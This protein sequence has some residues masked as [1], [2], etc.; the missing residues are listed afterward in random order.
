MKE[1]GPF[2]SKINQD[3]QWLTISNVLTVIRIIITPT[4]L[5]GIFHK[6]WKITFIIFI[7]TA[8]SDTLDG[9]LARYFNQKTI[10]GSILD[11]I[12]D[13]FFI[14]CCFSALTFFPS[15]SFQIPLWFFCLE[16][17]REATMIIGTYIVIKKATDVNIEPTIF[18]KLN[19][20][21]HTIFISWIFICNFFHWHP[22]KTF[23]VLLFTIALFSIM[24]LI[25]Y[26][27]LGIKIVFKNKT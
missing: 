6:E 17:F 2:K 16:I 12:A 19:T 22:E 10:L 4:I 18:G 24:S 5:L 23:M 25:H 26:V 9:F 8:L 14:I 11:P 27:S 13:K 1:P 7:I 20:F 21:F 15:P 3:Q